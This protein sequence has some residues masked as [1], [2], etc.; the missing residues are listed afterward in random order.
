ML[1][2]ALR[3]FYGLG[4]P[5]MGKQTRKGRSK[6]GRFVRLTHFM[7]NTPAWRSLTPVERAIYVELCQLYNGGNNG[8]LSAS[9]RRLADRCNVNKDTAAR[10]LK[11]LV[12]RGFI[13][14]ASPGGFSRKTP[15]AA[16]WR[17]TEYRC[18]RSHSLPTM[19]FQ[20]W[21]PDDKKD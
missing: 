6:D 8:T 18:D 16:E 12:E 2:P 1:A 5:A 7:L 10:A 20:G 17:L 4:A 11:T 19:E 13:I 3:P 9:V 14:C 21:R 15:H